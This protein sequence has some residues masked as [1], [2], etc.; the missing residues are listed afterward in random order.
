VHRKKLLQSGHVS[1]MTSHELTSSAAQA[2]H[3]QLGAEL[4]TYFLVCILVSTYWISI[5]EEVTYNQR[6]AREMSKSYS[7]S[8]VRDL[9]THRLEFDKMMYASPCT[10]VN[11]A[12]SGWH[13]ESH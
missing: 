4:K 3:A 13:R 8:R 5:A 9:L 7:G 11:Q 6:M 1:P 12:K 2:A 10:N